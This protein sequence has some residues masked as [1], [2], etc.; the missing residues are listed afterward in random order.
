[1]KKTLL[2]L[3]I[4]ASGTVMAEDKEVK[5]F[6]MEAEAGLI[7]TTGNTESTSAKGKITAHQELEKWSNDYIAELLYKKD[8]VNGQDQT[9]ARKLFA[10]AQGNYKLSN[11]DHRIFIFGSY[12]DDKFSSY[13]YQGTIAAGWNHKVWE[14]DTSKFE[15]SIGP[16]Y[17][18]AKT[19]AGESV[20]SA[21]LRAALD[22]QYKV[23]DTS[24]FKQLVSTEIGSDNTK[25]R[26][27]TSL[28]AQIAGK[29]AMKLSL[30]MDHNSDVAPGREKLDTQTAV[31]LVY[32]FF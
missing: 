17:S 8:E 10:S 22:Y 12:E 19:Q 6:T 16:G 3:A 21:I 31:T 20:N 26:S 5:P 32:T 27:E 30:T 29:L 2:C 15:Y 13:D 24:L 4:C 23:S 7:K 14:D 28:T 11:P 9:T 25:T 1:M 18:F